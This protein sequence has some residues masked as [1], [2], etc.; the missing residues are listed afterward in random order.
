MH[1]PDGFLNNGTAGSLLG[2]AAA[3]VVF[4]ASKVRSTFLEKVPV[5]RA[6]LA[7]FPD[8][9]SSSAFSIR[10][11]FSERGREKMWRMAS[12]G[13][14]IFSA[15]MVNFPIGGGTSGHVIGGV[16]AALVAGPLE[17]LLVLTVVLIVQAMVFGD[18]GILALGANIFNM[19]IVGGLG[20]YAFFRF[21]SQGKDVKRQ[22]LRNAFVAAWMSV[23]AAA[24][25]VSLEIAIS[26]TGPLS[27]V[28]PAMTLAHIVIG[29]AEGVI[30]V[31]ILAFLLNRGFSLS[32]LERPASDE[33]DDYVA[34]E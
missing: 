12:I 1:L 26:G 27:V 13:A 11:Q 32:A 22:F 5:L 10:R 4:A 18:G 20:G 31:F 28:L 29:F 24:V 7:T 14:L 9:G 21:L 23:I 2:A 34:K 6:K 3:A 25:A 16:I 30:T 8:F 15:Q 33:M 17:G 19:G